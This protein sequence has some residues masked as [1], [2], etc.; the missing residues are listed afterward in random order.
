M[1]TIQTTNIQTTIPIIQTTSSFTNTTNIQII[2]ITMPITVSTNF[3]QVNIKCKISTPE[4]L[5]YDLCISC[6]NERGFYPA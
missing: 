1:R 3:Y 5:E 6:N 4:S 2:Y